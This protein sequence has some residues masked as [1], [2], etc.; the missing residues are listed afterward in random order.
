MPVGPTLLPFEA[1]GGKPPWEA[2]Q[3]TTRIAEGSVL[4]PKAVK[5]KGTSVLTTA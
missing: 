1:V 4:R 2:E 3:T 5:Q